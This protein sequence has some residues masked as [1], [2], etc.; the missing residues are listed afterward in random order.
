MKS[1]R[2]DRN[3]YSF[4]S[5]D[6]R[7]ASWEIFD[8]QPPLWEIGSW[9]DTVKF[10][11]RNTR[12]FN[13]LTI[14]RGGTEDAV[15][16]TGSSDNTLKRFHIK[17]AGDQYVLTLKGGS[18]NNRFIDW[19]IGIPPKTVDIEIGN[20]SSSSQEPSPNNVFEGWERIDGKPITYCYRLFGCKPTFRTMKVKHKWWRSIGLTVY[21]WSKYLWHIVLRRPDD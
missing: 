20:W 18:Y 10:Y 8:P 16:M 17:Q 11:K 21:W 1:T 9:Q 6:Q 2:H 4:D 3:F 15:D 14:V 12:L 5:D 13:D 7:D 19:V